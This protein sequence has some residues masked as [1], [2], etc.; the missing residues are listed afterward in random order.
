VAD[1]AAARVPEN[2]ARPDPLIDREQ[3]QLLSEHPVIRRCS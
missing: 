2:Q 3:I 1:D